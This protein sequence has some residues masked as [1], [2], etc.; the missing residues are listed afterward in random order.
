MSTA[1]RIGYLLGK[2]GD[3]FLKG[4]GVTLLLAVVGTGIG[5]LLGLGLALLR[6]LKPTP[7]DSK[8]KSIPQLI[9]A[10]CADLY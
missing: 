7:Q 1:D 10:D 4:V 8:F 5:L 2:Y 9:A 3:L 6:N